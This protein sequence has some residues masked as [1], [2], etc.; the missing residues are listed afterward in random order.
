MRFK[1]GDRVLVIAGND[2]GQTG[3]VL[4]IMT[5]QGKV[6]VQGVNVRWKHRKATQ[7]NPKGERVQSEFPIDASNVMPIDPKTGKGTR[8]ISS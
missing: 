2:K 7:K 5:K 1:K 8:K 3:E 6:L 4:E